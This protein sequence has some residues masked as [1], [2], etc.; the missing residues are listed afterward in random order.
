MTNF[1]FEVKRER[2]S[3]TQ[4]QAAVY[5]NGL[6]LITYGDSIELKPLNAYGPII[7]GWASSKP[8]KI[9]IMAAMKDCLETIIELI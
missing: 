8:D 3:V 4:G 7:G 6:R 2:W 5:C 9:F 1:S